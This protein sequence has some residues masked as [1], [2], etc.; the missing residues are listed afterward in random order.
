MS[1]PVPTSEREQLMLYAQVVG[2]Y[3]TAITQAGIILGNALVGCPFN[4][5]TQ[6]EIR[7]YFRQWIAFSPED[8]DDPTRPIATAYV[9]R[10]IAGDNILEEKPNPEEVIAIIERW[11]AG[12]PALGLTRSFKDVREVL[13]RAIGQASH[14]IDGFTSAV[15]QVKARVEELNEQA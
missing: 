11:I 1:E 6:D 4:G 14:D 2:T 5:G 9:A 13:G 8:Q 10:A 3:A 7:D 15:K 12:A